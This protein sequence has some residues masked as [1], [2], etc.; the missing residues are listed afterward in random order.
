M[1]TDVLII[2]AGI[3]GLST[4]YQLQQSFPHLKIRVLEKERQS[5]THQS[6]HNSGVVHSGVYYKPGSMK[7]QNCTEG[8]AALLAFCKENEIFPE[9][10]GKVIV[11]TRET[12]LPFLAELQKR[13]D[14]N[15]VKGLQMIGPKQLKEIEPHASGIQALWV[16]ECYSI[17]FQDVVEKLLMHFKKKGGEILFDKKVERITSEKDRVIVETANSTHT[18]SYLINC[19]GLHSDRIASLILDREQIPFQIIP[20]RGEYWELAEP[21]RDLVK[22][23]IYPVPDPKFPFLGV[24]LS[25]MVGGKVVAGPNAVLALAREGYKKSQIDL[26]DCLQYLRYP[27]FWKMA[28]RY[29]NVGL[30]EMQRSL[31][32]KAFVK[33]VQRLLP[34]LEEEDFIKS[35]AGV[36]AQ[37]VKRDGTMLDDFAIVSKH[38]TLHVLN[39]PSPAATSC[40]SIAKY[41]CK[42]MEPF[43]G[44]EPVK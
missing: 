14:S 19:A 20:F 17:R 3:I 26:R 30:S 15:G 8:R 21:K 32:K 7:A 29:W 25:R 24:H 10:M 13:G 5:G 11:A 40:L 27:G 31:R 18:T 42:Q 2:G 16:P 28:G 23:L 22:G 43:I 1:Q 34:E 4:A 36:R 35:D 39:A 44:K 38:N 41:I 37:V 12:E 6:T 9:K 33:E